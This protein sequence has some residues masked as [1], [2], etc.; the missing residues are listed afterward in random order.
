MIGASACRRVRPAV[1]VA[2][3]CRRSG[4]QPPCSDARTTRTSV[5][6]RGLR[7]PGYHRSTRTRN[8]APGSGG[9]RDSH[10]PWL[11]GL[12]RGRFIV[13]S[14]AP[15]TAGI[16]LNAATT[17]WRTV[18]GG[19]GCSRV[20]PPSGGRRAAQDSSSRWYPPSVPC[21]RSPPVDARGE[22]HSGTSEQAAAA[23]HR[24]AS[25]RRRQAASPP[26]RVRALAPHRKTPY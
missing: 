17:R 20:R 21:S 18:D 6:A 24:P 5:L 9:A 15:C 16:R 19:G 10:I 12:S 13:V 11:I 26:T 7:E 2:G 1:P 23:A 8:R 22:Q 14:S 3:R 4:I 25:V